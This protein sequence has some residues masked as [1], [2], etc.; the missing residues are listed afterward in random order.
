MFRQL[1]KQQLE[2]VRNGGEPMNVFRD[3]EKN[4][5]LDLEPPVGTF[6]KLPPRFELDMGYDNGFQDAYGPA[7]GLLI[8]LLERVEESGVMRIDPPR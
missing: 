7:I 1:L 4:V 8:D 2:L 5:C 6:A 3:P